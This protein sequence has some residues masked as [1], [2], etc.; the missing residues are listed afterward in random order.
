[1]GLIYKATKKQDPNYIYIGLTV[2]SLEERRRQH[3]RNP[4][5]WNLPSDAFD[6]ILIQEGTNNWNWEILK[7][8]I[9][10]KDL[11]DYETK[12]I[13]EHLNKGY[14]LANKDKNKN[15]K[16]KKP[17]S[18]GSAVSWNKSNSHANVARYMSGK[19]KPVKNLTTGSEY[20]AI[21]TIR[22]VEKVSTKLIN[23][24]CET[25]EPNPKNGHQY[26]FLD[27]EGNPI[28]KEGHKKNY[29]IL[30]KIEIINLKTEKIH[31]DTI[32]KIAPIIGC[33]LGEL[34]AMKHLNLG[35][36]KNTL[37]IKGYLVFHIDEKGNRI[38][39]QK[40]KIKLERAQT[41]REKIYVWEWDYLKTKWILVKSCLGLKEVMKYLEEINSELF[42]KSSM[43]KIRE[44]INPQK[45]RTNIN[46]Y[47]FTIDTIAP[48]R[49]PFLKNQR[50]IYLNKNGE[51]QIFNSSKHAA[52]FFNLNVESVSS[53]CRGTIDSTQGKRFAYSNQNG[54]PKYTNRHNAYMRKAVGLGYSVY[55]LEGD[56]KFSSISELR[57]YLV[58]LNEEQDPRIPYVPKS[59]K[60]SKIM[61]GE[62]PT[63]LGREPY[64]FKLTLN[65]IK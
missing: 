35:G 62:L 53:C 65:E 63:L 24:L 54:E 22:N 4:K 9:A 51:H 17:N 6:Q 5:V 39:T 19:I 57:R 50:V 55:W 40:H 61:R 56:K 15:Y 12:F 27:L 52:I 8:N 23:K 28:L 60:L 11:E 29:Q 48:E 43:G 25:G 32:F 45:S 41:E 59:E 20:N 46:K 58:K 26:A 14:K 7:A 30:N 21:T 49:N 2:L 37:T 31:K 47:S 33:G 3:E 13:N 36:K 16:S 42:N 34:L 18:Q 44:I 38:E 64:S 1:M 10:D